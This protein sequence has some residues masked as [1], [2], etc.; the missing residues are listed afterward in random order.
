[1]S[2][3]WALGSAGNR[4]HSCPIT[5]AGR[6]NDGTCG[7]DHWDVCLRPQISVYDILHA[8]REITRSPGATTES[9][10]KIATDEN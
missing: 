10:Y 3:L 4:L 1:M 9:G 7:N 6:I 5:P 8:N 2:R